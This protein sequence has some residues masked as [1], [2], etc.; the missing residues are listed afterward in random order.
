MNILFGIGNRL[1]DFVIYWR[2]LLQPE[3]AYLNFEMLSS[4]ALRINIVL[5]A[6]IA[7]A[8]HSSFL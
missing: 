3:L 8:G 2:C 7:C 1:C 4:G 6:L 5:P